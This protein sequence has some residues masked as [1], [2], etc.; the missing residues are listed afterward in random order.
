MKSDLKSAIEKAI[1]QAHQDYEVIQIESLNLPTPIAAGDAETAVDDFDSN[2]E[3]KLVTFKVQMR[4]KSRPAPATSTADNIYDSVGKLNVPFLLKNAAVL[5][6]SR[7]FS[8]AR[9]IYRAII[10]SGEKTAQGFAGLGNCFEA[11]GKLKE[12]CEAFEESIAYQ[13]TLEAYQKLSECYIK[14]GKDKNAAEVLE[15]AISLR[16]LDDS[17]RFEMHNACGNAWMKAD[18]FENA[19]SHY[20]RALDLNPSADEIKCNLGALCLKFQKI[21]EARQHF[22]DALAADPTNAKALIGMGTCYLATGS[23]QDKRLAHDFFARALDIEINHPNAI[24]HLVKCAYDL[25]T[26]A[27][28]TR[29]LEEYIQSA[30]V[31]VSLLYSLA[32]LQY[33]LKRYVDA[34]ET[35]TK[36]ENLNPAHGPSQELKAR[37]NKILKNN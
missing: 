14:R 27:P 17:T 3:S 4:H 22:Q 9:N 10:Q 8:L 12:A 35:L 11:E 26:Y 29:I 13:S 6:E 7:D 21:D 34:R 30:P 36:I 2:P 32:G 19:T 25:K 23:H 33:H 16:N 24:F 28:A 31:S 37:I 18:Q 20:H 15:R 5:V 1:H